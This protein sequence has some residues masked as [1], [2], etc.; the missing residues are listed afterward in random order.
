MEKRGRVMQI[1]ILR[2]QDNNKQSFD[3]ED[4][5]QTLLSAL[6]HIKA[7]QDAS[8]TFSAGCRAS[9]CGTCAVRVNGKE[10]LS[11][12]YKVQDGDIIEPLNY[13]PILR[14]L[15]VD[16]QKAKSTLKKSTAWLHEP[17]DAIL[18]EKD[19]ALSERQSDCILCDSCYSAC[20]VYAVNSDFLGP[21]ALTRAYRYSEDKRE[22]NKK[23]IIDNIQS[24]GVWDCTLCGECTA[25]C[26]KGIDPKMDIVM[27]RGLSVQEGYD[28]PSFAMQS[29]ATPDFGFNPNAGF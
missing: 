2:S 6:N 29:F 7:T 14:D 5:N 1:T 8:L 23:D 13:H 15:K 16:K 18:D 10:V 26:P 27:L 20:P 3:I 4:K 24:N 17:I 9:V 21:F 25:V 12:A 11:C 22:D 28:D 19:E